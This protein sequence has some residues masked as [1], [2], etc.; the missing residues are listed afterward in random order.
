MVAC[1]QN[2]ILYMAT[3]YGS[4]RRELFVQETPLFIFKK[5]AASFNISGIPFHYNLGL[6]VLDNIGALY[7]HPCLQLRPRSS[8]REV[9]RVG[10]RYY[11]R[12][13]RRE[14]KEGG[15][16][17]CW[18]LVQGGSGVFLNTSDLLH[19]DR[20]EIWMRWRSFFPRLTSL[21]VRRD[22]LS[23]CDVAEQLNVSGFVFGREVVRCN[24][25]LKTSSSC[26]PS[27]LKY[28]WNAD[29]DCDCTASTRYLKCN[30]ND[31]TDVK[32]ERSN[33]TQMGNMRERFTYRGYTRLS[34]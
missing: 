18:F 5:Q 29:K 15:S 10:S 13:S 24:C 23:W 12:G 4:V 11:V 25:G 6:K 14:V 2:L 7:T 20:M 17:G 21:Q 3:V 33:D 32:I 9:L 16:F 26:V 31:K 34:D 30:I 22:D 19:A 28:G 27:D 1:P 8:V